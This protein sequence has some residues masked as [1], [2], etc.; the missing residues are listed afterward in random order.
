MLEAQNMKKYHP[1]KSYVSTN[2]YKTLYIEY[3][4]ILPQENLRVKLQFI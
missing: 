2:E 1:T 4:E 3:L